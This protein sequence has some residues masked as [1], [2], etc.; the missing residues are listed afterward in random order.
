MW[1]HKIETGSQRRG[2][3]TTDGRDQP[4]ARTV[5][6]FYASLPPPPRRAPLVLFYL[7]SNNLQQL[8]FAYVRY[9][10]LNKGQGCL[11][12]PTTPFADNIG[13]AHSANICRQIFK[14]VS[15]FLSP[16]RVGRFLFT[17]L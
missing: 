12:P 7:C 13:A 11:S 17:R 9:V 2:M 6:Q 15:F 4:V 3:Q 16:H 10:A 5:A 14:P 1:G 8:P